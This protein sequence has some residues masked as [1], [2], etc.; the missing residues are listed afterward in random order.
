MIRPGRVITG[1]TAGGQDRFQATCAGNARSNDVAY[2]LRLTR[3][4]LVRINMSTQDWD[5]ALHVRRD[6]ADGSTEVAC[7]DDQNDN[8]HSFIEQT[9]D[10]GTYH[11]IVDGFSQGNQGTYT[12][13]VQ[14]SQQ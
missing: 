5:G 7:N 1:T 9:L 4:S 6:C 10:P 14:V 12:L 2:R 13:D 3:R 8:R 11:V